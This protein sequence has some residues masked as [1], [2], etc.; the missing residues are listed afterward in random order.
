LFKVA[1]GFKVGFC[2]DSPVALR[3]S[4]SVLSGY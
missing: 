1:E 2:E 4:S 3:D